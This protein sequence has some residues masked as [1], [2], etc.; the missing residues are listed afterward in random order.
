M[1]KMKTMAA[2][3]ALMVAAA[4]AAL[5]D[6]PQPGFS[7]GAL[8]GGL[9]MTSDY[10]FRGIS[11]TD[12]KPALQGHF[13]YAA[14]NGFYLGLWGSNVDFND[15]GKTSLEADPYVGYKFDNFGFTWDVG[16]IGHVYP[17]SN[18]GRDHYN[19][20]EGKLATSETWHT[21]TMTASANYSPSFI[22]DSG[23]ATYASLALEAPLADSGFSL[24]ATGGYQ[25]VEKNA[26]FGLPDYGDWSA[27]L[28][29]AWK[30]FDFAVKYTDT[31][32]SK[33]D[34]RDV[35]DAR[36][37]FSISRSFN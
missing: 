20:F 35:C 33:N 13:D 10:I 7:N 30:G 4:G 27:K 11:Q 17:G 8:S 12:E 19:Y 25:W 14:P 18:Q 3:A 1:K 16:A 5:A 36:A 29:Y 9:A 6:E 22:R 15:G 23:N 37:V 2:L 31:N 21:I 28:G 24:G 26:T 32:V 34:C